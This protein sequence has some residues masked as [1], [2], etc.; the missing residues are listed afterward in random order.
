MACVPLIMMQAA[1]KPEVPVALGVDTW[2]S[3]KASADARMR[4]SCA[5]SP[6]GKLVLKIRFW[7]PPQGT[8]LSRLPFDHGL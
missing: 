7:E 8:V 1:G 2:G 3:G 6:W 4:P 5:Q